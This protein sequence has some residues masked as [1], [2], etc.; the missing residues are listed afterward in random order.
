MEKEKRNGK[1]GGGGWEG[2]KEGTHAKKKEMFKKTYR[3][4]LNHGLG[5]KFLLVLETCGR[6]KEEGGKK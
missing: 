1:R 2:R 3:L 6:T 4:N 5:P